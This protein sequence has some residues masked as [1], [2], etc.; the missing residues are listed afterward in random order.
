MHQKLLTAIAAQPPKPGLD[1]ALTGA[2]PFAA[3]IDGGARTILDPG[4]V[5]DLRA[6][7]AAY[8]RAYRAVPSESLLPLARDQIRLA[9]SL[10]P[11]TQPESV[12]T[13]LVRH[14]GEMA[15]LAGVVQMLDLGDFVQAEPF[16]RLGATVAKAIGDQ[17][18]A[19]VV[20]ACRAFHTGYSGHREDGLDWALAAR[21]SAAGGASPRTSAWVA[22]VASE[23]HASLGNHDACLE[24]LEQARQAL[25]QPQQDARWSGDRLVG[26]GEGRRLRGRRLGA[27][28]PLRRGG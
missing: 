4:I 21:D 14:I 18:L 26:R 13:D 9:F 8:R 22:A 25:Q 15:A 12:R 6:T 16:L 24:A 7:S 17:E 10:Q 27:P 5:A 20:Y 1:C 19:A 28:G 23:M 2:G 11:G 3:V